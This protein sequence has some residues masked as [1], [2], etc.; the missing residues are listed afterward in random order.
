MQTNEVTVVPANDAVKAPPDTVTA[1][2]AVRLALDD[3]TFGVH[4]AGAVPPAKVMGTLAAD[5][6]LLMP[7]MTVLSAL[8]KA[9]SRRLVLVFPVTPTITA[10]GRTN[11]L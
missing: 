3:V 9:E 10:P 7:T 1:V 2:P 4:E 11:L 5:E 6:P 8:V